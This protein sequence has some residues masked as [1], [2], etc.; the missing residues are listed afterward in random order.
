M[1]C[2]KKRGFRQNVGIL[3]SK[4][5]ILDDFSSRLGKV[6]ASIALLSLLEKLVFDDFSSR[7][8]RSDASIALL[9]LLEKLV[10]DDYSSRLG[11]ADAS[12]AL[13]SLLE[14]FKLL[15]WGI[16]LLLFFAREDLNISELF[17]GNT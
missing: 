4:I 16:G 12:I 9:S 3:F 2:K 5:I 8:G 17:V 13:P 7:L 14:K 1:K 10:F 11:R 6:D 15:V